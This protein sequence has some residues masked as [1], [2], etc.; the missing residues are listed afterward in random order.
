MI[1]RLHQYID[2]TSRWVNVHAP[3]LTLV[4]HL[5]VQVLLGSGEKAMHTTATTAQVLQETLQSYRES[6]WNNQQAYDRRPKHRKTHVVDEIILPDSTITLL[7]EF[8]DTLDWLMTDYDLQARLYTEAVGMPP[9]EILTIQSFGGDGFRIHTSAAIIIIN[10]WLLPHVPVCKIWADHELIKIEDTEEIDRYS[11][12]HTNALILKIKHEGTKKRKAEYT[13]EVWRPFQWNGTARDI[14]WVRRPLI[15]AQFAVEDINID[16]GDAVW[17]VHAPTREKYLFVYDEKHLLHI[18]SPDGIVY[19]TVNVELPTYPIEDIQKKGDDFVVIQKMYNPQENDYETIY[20]LVKVDVCKKSSGDQDVSREGHVVVSGTFPIKSKIGAS[21]QWE[22]WWSMEW[23]TDLHPLTFIP[24]SRNPKKVIQCYANRWHLWAF[25]GDTFYLIKREGFDTRNIEITKEVK[26]DT[27]RI[28]PIKWLLNNNLLMGER[29]VAQYDEEQNERQY[30]EWP[31]YENFSVVTHSWIYTYQG[32]PL[33]LLGTQAWALLV[34]D[35]AQKTYRTLCEE[36]WATRDVRT[37]H[38]LTSDDWSQIQQWEIQQKEP[39]YLVTSSHGTMRFLDTRTMFLGE[40]LVVSPTD[41]AH[42][43]AQ[44]Y[45]AGHIADTTTRQLEFT[46]KKYKKRFWQ[47]DPTW[48]VRINAD[49]VS[50]TRDVREREWYFVDKKNVLYVTDSVRYVR[51]IWTIKTV[52][53]ADDNKYE[54]LEIKNLG[55]KLHKFVLVDGSVVIIDEQTG[56]VTYTTKDIP[57]LQGEPV[58]SDSIKT[59]LLRLG[60]DKRD[61]GWWQAFWE[62]VIATRRLRESGDTTGL[63]SKK[64][65]YV[66]DPEADR[67]GAF[68]LNEYRYSEYMTLYF[69][70]SRAREIKEIN[71][72]LASMG[73]I[74]EYII[75]GGHGLVGSMSPWETLTCGDFKDIFNIQPPTLQSTVVPWRPYGTEIFFLSCF[76]WAESWLVEC[77]TEAA[78]YARRISWEQIAANVAITEEKT[79][80]G[81]TILH[82][83]PTS[84]GKAEKPWVNRV[85]EKEAEDEKEKE[86]K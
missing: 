58:M 27:A 85:K 76:S 68:M 46:D 51:K 23:Y 73:I 1:W 62:E 41:T 78:P 8:P 3:A 30:L 29:G 18:C 39:F 64:M 50:W 35:K 37:L 6:A 17:Q 52:Y 16:D 54:A 14:L 12:E 53:D 43:N 72:R 9:Q 42:V 40:P 45:T 57:S 31:E 20:T 22:I 81:E 7:E 55:G 60:I 63:R 74:P 71:Q 38:S 32:A 33:C 70:R 28:G 34:Y 66:C 21:A 5:L 84:G 24:Q 86:K 10:P 80:S 61:R 65:V 77:M 48:D 67:N 83:K 79:E 82:Y 47:H 19:Y 15:Y 44:T 49:S 25:F 75:I 56:A 69:Q 59:E 4:A 26:I 13:Q 2:R 36:P 11:G